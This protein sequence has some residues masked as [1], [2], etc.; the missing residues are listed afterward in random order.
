MEQRIPSSATVR[1]PSLRRSVAVA[2]ENQQW[3]GA[4]PRSAAA[5]AP[6]VGL[7]GQ[8]AIGRVQVRA[9]DRPPALD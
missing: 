8:H 9:V 6:G 3:L 7:A 2:A 5:E 4:L 1:R